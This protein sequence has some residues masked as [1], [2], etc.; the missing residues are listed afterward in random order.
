MFCIFSLSW[1]QT[2]FFFRYFHYVMRVFHISV[3]SLPLEF[4]W[5][6]IYLFIYFNASL[7]ISAFYCLLTSTL[8]EKKSLHRPYSLFIHLYADQI[9]LSNSSDSS[10]KCPLKFFF[11]PFFSEIIL[12]YVKMLYTTA[13]L[14]ICSKNI[15][16]RKKLII[17]IVSWFLLRHVNIS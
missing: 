5:Q 2:S 1:F 3:N 13:D 15:L 11:L 4:E 7:G 6:I 12:F 10:Q 14:V 17:I 16:L 8:K 9:L